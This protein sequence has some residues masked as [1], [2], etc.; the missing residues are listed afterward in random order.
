M[1]DIDYHPF[2]E[3]EVGGSIAYVP[4]ENNQVEITNL[5]SVEWVNVLSNPFKTNS[6]NDI[7]YRG[8]RIGIGLEEGQ[9]PINK[10]HLIGDLFITENYD[11]WDFLRFYHNGDTAF[12]DFGG[13]E[14]GVC[15]RMNNGT[16][17]FQD[18][19]TMN[20]VMRFRDNKIGILKNNP[21][22]ALDVNGSINSTSLYI[23]EIDIN[24]VINTLINDR[25]YL[26]I[27]SAST[28]Y[29]TTT[30]ATSTY[31]TIT[32]LNTKENALT[33]SAPL[34]RTTNTISLDLSAY[35]T[36]ALRNTALSNYLTTTTAG[37]T[38]ATITNLNAK[39]NALT[40]SA[41]LTRTTNTISLDLSA[42][43]TIALRNTALSNYLTTTTAGTT[44]AT[45]TNLNAK[46]NA[47]TFSAPLTR[48]TNTISLDL[49]AYDTIA[50]RNTALSSYITT[51]NAN[52]LNSRFFNNNGNDHTTLNNFNSVSQF[53]YNY[54]LGTANGPN[55]NSASQ[56]YSW[57]IGL[58]SQ[59]A[60]GTYGAQFAIARNITSPYLCVRY[61]ENG[62]Y[63]A[64]SKLSCGYADSAGT[65]AYANITGTPNLALK[66]DLLTASTVILGTGGSITG[67][68]Y[69][70]ISNTPNL[71]LKQD[72]LTAS[73]VILGTG[74]SITGLNYNNISNT[75]NLALKQDTL[76]FSNPFLNTAN[77]I[78]LKYD[79]TKL[80]IDGSGNLTVISGTS[81]WNTSGTSIYYNAGKI[82]IGLTNP[83]NILQIKGTTAYSGAL[84]SIDSTTPPR[85]IGQPLINIGYSS[86]TSGAVAGDYYGIGY[87]FNPAY[88][89]NI[90]SCCEIGALIQNSGGAE[91]GDLVFATRPNT[92]ST[93]IATERMRIT[94]NGNIGIGTTNPLTKFTI[95]N[96]YG[97]GANG[98]FCLDARDVSSTY[99][100]KIFSFVQ[101]GG[102]VGYYFQV[103]NVSS[104]VNALTLG[105]SGNVGIGVSMPSKKLEVG[106][107]TFINGDNITFYVDANDARLGILKTYGHL[108]KICASSGSDIIFAN[109]SSGTLSQTINSYHSHT[110]RVIIKGDSGNMGIGTITPDQKLDVKGNVRVGVDGVGYCR[111]DSGGTGNTCGYIAFY[112]SAGTRRGYIGWAN[113]T[114]QQYLSMAVESGCLGYWM[115]GTFICDGTIT[116]LFFAINN[117]GTDYLG[118]SFNFPDTSSAVQKTICA[119]L[120]SFTGFHRCFTNDE[121]YNEESEE[122]IKDF[123]FKYAGRVVIASGKIATDDSITDEN[124][125]TE[126]NIKYD[127]E[128][129]TLEDALPI[130]QLSRQR[131]DKR[132]FGVLGLPK[133]NNSRKERMIINS[134][135]EGGIWVVNTNGNIE[136]GDYLQTSDQL[137]Y[138]EKQDD[139]L[140]HNYTIGKSTIDCNFELN[141]DKYETVVLENGFKASFIACTYHC[142]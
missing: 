86:Y 80:S 48:T 108:P 60:F 56:Y 29:L 141:N 130:V 126:W 128:G 41:P 66:Q 101:A 34:T 39:E 79:N 32:N 73:T 127:K 69:N 53:G 65:V 131:K 10:L 52:I 106:G 117:S 19:P 71:A 103:N 134:V 35:D 6:T 2:P 91:Y 1:A 23:N 72:L 36:I 49:S 11:T 28:T 120:G 89:A 109:L 129:I 133:R 88:S 104:S 4:F 84:M 136:N 105:Y 142:G 99:N 18:N 61:Q 139:D 17:S 63:N 113:Q 70:N 13:V 98:G 132:V 87:G 107:T 20:E 74:G 33:F 59:Y 54:I 50:L 30:T 68:N 7:I 51:A 16:T 40:F 93:E 138:G 42:Y 58:G 92:T 116:A 8:N 75:P 46:E 44:Y 122:T 62:T 115:T 55:V 95:R 102:Q 31:A 22:Y 112:N 57:S 45:I 114:S 85:G 94:Y 121:L 14:N 125:N 3:T 47:L 123:K 97:D 27:A 111:I 38:Y 76:T 64:W 37:T 119:M 26:S 82:G 140:L 25:N 90:K 124:N 135:G 15:F 137:G 43:D 24:T 100:L 9:S 83:E 77:T 118:V 67:L 110:D 5:N 78:S 81:Q 12:L 21:G 96:A